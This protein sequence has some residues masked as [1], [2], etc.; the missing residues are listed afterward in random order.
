MG[1]LYRRARGIEFHRYHFERNRVGALADVL[2]MKQAVAARPA[3]FLLVM[4]PVFFEGTHDFA[5]YPL[6]DIHVAVLAF[7]KQNGIEAFDLLPA[8]ERSGHD[9]AKDALDPWHLSPQGHELVARELAPLV[10]PRQ[11]GARET[12]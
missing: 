11:N 8:F 10:V 9:T 4:L 12:R 5:D 2:A 3:S 6:R 7:C 1:V